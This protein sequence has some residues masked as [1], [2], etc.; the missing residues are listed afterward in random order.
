MRTALGIAVSVMLVFAFL[1]HIAPAA[2]IR[3]FSRDPN[4]IAVG[5]EYLRIVSWNFVAAGTVFVASSMFQAI[6]NTVPSLICS[7]VRILMAIVPALLL[8]RLPA[9]QLRW[10]WYLAVASVTTQVILILI[11]LRGELRKRLAFAPV[12]EDLHGPEGAFAEAAK[13]AS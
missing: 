2:M 3:L 4:V 12:A 1:C 6:G 8:A 9:F 7:F 5:E 11:L 10:V 13:P